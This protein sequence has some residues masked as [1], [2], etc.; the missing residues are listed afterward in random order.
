MKARCFSVLAVLFL[1]QS[2][3]RVVTVQKP[4]DLAIVHASVLDVRTGR[5]LTNQSVFVRD[6]IISAISP[7]RSPEAAAQ[8]VIDARGRLLTPGL[9]DAHLHTFLILG[10]SL[11]M[12]P[13]SIEAYRRLLAKT[14]L[15]YGVTVVR[16]VGTS[17][18]WMPMLL[19][20]MERTSSAP[21]FYPTGAH[22]VSPEAGRTPP[23]YQV[24]VTDS[25]AAAAK[26]REYFALGIRDIKLYWRLQEPEFKGAYFE[27]Q[28]LGMNVTGHVDLQVMTIDR[29]LDLGLR[30]LEHVHTIAYS[31]MTKTGFDSIMAEMP[32][33]LG[34]RPP[35]FPPTALYMNVPELWNYLGPTN[36]RVLALLARIK[37]VDASVTPTLHVFAQRLGLAY[38][39]SAPRDSTEN[40]AV[41]TAEQRARAIAGYKVM[42]S[43]VKRMYEAGIRL[44]LGTDAHDPGKAALSEML[45][46]HDAGIPMTAVFR[47]ATLDTAEDIGH[48]WEY[49]SIDVGKRA[50][51]ILFDGDPLTR[52]ADL[53][54]TKTVIKDG[55]VWSNGQ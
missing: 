40:T 16:D 35:R 17:E 46:L 3:G 42:A 36:P 8:Q 22:L 23:A 37:A 38:F 21:D 43:Y 33:T 49:G 51:L 48:G 12:H 39:Q 44:D 27:A 41:W 2:A 10:D 53:V 11:V 47:I 31:L 30:H 50:D 4:V 7:T 52:P 19:K 20:W 24:V 15:P 29:A 34:I 25:A 28:R 1:P 54:G 32:T 14:Y 5:V 55:V 45:L 26:V 9:I 13:D 6:G 18:R